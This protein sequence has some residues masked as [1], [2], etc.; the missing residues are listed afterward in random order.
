MGNGGSR[1]SNS[2][3]NDNDNNNIDHPGD[4][5]ADKGKRREVC[6]GGEEKR[7]RRGWWTGRGGGRG[8]ERE[9]GVCRG[10]TRGALLHKIVKPGPADG[11]GAAPR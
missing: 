10:G 1:A 8:R 2:L 7:E 4:G 11:G 6:N 5:F 3:S 9:A